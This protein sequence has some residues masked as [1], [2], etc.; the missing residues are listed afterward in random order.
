[1]KSRKYWE[2]IKLQLDI[3]YTI[4][5]CIL[6]RTKCKKRSLACNSNISRIGGEICKFLP[7]KLN[8]RNM[9]NHVFWLKLTSD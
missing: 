5:K 1:M 9:Q 7:C 3:N 8:A 6:A 4:K 2:N